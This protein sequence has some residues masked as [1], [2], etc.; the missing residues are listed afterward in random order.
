MNAAGTLTKPEANASYYGS[1]Y[2]GG[3][4]GGNTG[5]NG[6]TGKQH[7][8]TQVQQALDNIST[9][10]S[11]TDATAQISNNPIAMAAFQ[12]KMRQYDP[13]WNPT[14]SNA[15]ASANIGTA[16]KYIQQSADIQ[17]SISTLNKVASDLV[18]N[19][20]STGFNPTSSPIGNET[21][22]QYFTE[23]NPAAKA[24]ITKGL[25]DIETQ[26]SKVISASTGLTPSG[27][28]D[29]I[30]NSGIDFKNL[31]PQ[32]LSDFIQYVNNYAQS[33]LGSAQEAVKGS[34]GSYGAYTGSPATSGS[35]PNPKAN[36]TLQAAAGTGAGL[37]KG[38]IS[39][40][41]SHLNA[42]T[43]AAIGGLAEKVLM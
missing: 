33:N 20:G 28:T 4:V 26:M 14:S 1:P 25:Q 38:L 13:N 5:S 18:P 27:V 23:K 39:A 41:G 42:V 19:M 35:L 31:N 10:A 30:Q 2:S 43:G 36:S 7:N 21:F 37:A 11:T 22:Q 17:N 9:G 29:Q 34:L 8:D 16:Q 40:I 12:S 32:Q 15:I 24:G 6:S 3:L